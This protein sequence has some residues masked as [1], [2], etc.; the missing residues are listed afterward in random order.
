MSY[1]KA[2]KGINNGYEYKEVDKPNFA[3]FKFIEIVFIQ[4]DL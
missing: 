1:G 2:K 4:I 3:F